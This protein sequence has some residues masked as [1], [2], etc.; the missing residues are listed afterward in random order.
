[1]PRGSHSKSSRFTISVGVSNTIPLARSV[2]AAVEPLAG[3]WDQGDLVSR[4][5]MGIIRLT[6]WHRGQE[7]FANFGRP[8]HLC[9]LT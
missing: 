2:E 3:S 5:I 1:M 8:G 7:E 9:K 4:L 6:I